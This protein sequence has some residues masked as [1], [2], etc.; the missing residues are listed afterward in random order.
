MIEVD[1]VSHVFQNI[2]FEDNGCSL[3]HKPHKLLDLLTHNKHTTHSY[4][5]QNANKINA[6]YNTKNMNWQSIHNSITTEKNG[7]L[8]DT[9]LIVQHI[10]N[11]D[12]ATSIN[13]NV[14]KNCMTEMLLLDNTK[15]LSLFDTGST[16]NLISESVIKSS[17]YLSSLPI[18]KCLIFRIHNTSDEMIANNIQLYIGKLFP[19]DNL[20]T[21][22]FTIKYIFFIYCLNMH[23]KIFIM[24]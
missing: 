10:Q 18:M 4:V 6:V 12:N 21:V 20:I 24:G 16:V 13:I 17:V 11:D 15:L 7:E 9:D 19:I 1:T 8:F 2:S 22:S 3:C 5:F 14:N 23:P